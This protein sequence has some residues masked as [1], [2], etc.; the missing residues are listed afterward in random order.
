MKKLKIYILLILISGVFYNCTPGMNFFIKNLTN[1][2]ILIEYSISDDLLLDGF[3]KSDTTILNMD[4]EIHV[5]LSW[6]SFYNRGIS[7]EDYKYT[8]TFLSIFDDITI[9]F[10]NENIVLTKKELEKYI[11][12]YRKEGISSHIFT[13]EI[14]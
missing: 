11:I 10:I 12:K 6:Q 5:I 9:T 4:D 8:S 3:E 14:E 1:E 7:Q 13:L 2:N